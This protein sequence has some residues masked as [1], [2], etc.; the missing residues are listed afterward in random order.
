[1]KADPGSGR[2]ILSTENQ[3]RISHRCP[4]IKMK[5]KHPDN[6]HNDRYSGCAQ[7]LN[8]ARVA[9]QMDLDVFTGV[10]WA[11]NLCLTM[12]MFG[13]ALLHEV[14][15]CPTSGN[16]SQFAWQSCSSWLW[17]PH[18]FSSVPVWTMKHAAFPSQKPW[19][20]LSR[21]AP[22]H[23]MPQMRV[24]LGLAWQNALVAG[25]PS[26]W[27]SPHLHAHI[28]GAKQT[29]LLTCGNSSVCVQASKPDRSACVTAFSGLHLRLSGK[30]QYGMIQ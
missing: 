2:T 14:H 27:I 26:W 19:T 10:V 18:S 7:T 21:P 16:M 29:L 28:L 13:W 12:K 1:M 25:C 15:W 17:P 30:S 24:F 8:S 11:W 6:E 9:V 20:D 4:L 3:V 23:L 5:V 22:A